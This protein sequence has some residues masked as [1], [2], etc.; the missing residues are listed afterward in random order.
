[1]TVDKQLYTP[2]AW[3]TIFHSLEHDEV[4]GAGAAGPGKS[5]V[6]LMDPFHWQI[7]TEHER[8]KNP[9]HPHRLPWGGSS[10]WA[11]HLRRT[12]PMLELSI[13]R[14]HRI[15]PLIDAGAKWNENK[16]T[17]VFRSGYRFQ[18]G[19]CHDSEDWQNYLSFEFTHIGYDELIQFEEEQYD[20][21]N[22]R[23]RSSDPVLRTMLKIRATTNPLMSKQK[24]DNFSIKDP[25]WVRRRFVDDAPEGKVT[26][27][28]K[29]KMQDGRVVEHKR[30]YL[31]ATLFD[32][33]DKQFVQDYEAKL[34]NAK[35]HIRQ[36]LLYGN[37]YVT[38]GS[39]YGDVWNT[40]L[41]TCKPFK[42][43]KEWPKFRSM[44]WGFKMPGVVHWYAMDPDG[45]L[46]CFRE[47]VFQGMQAKAV[48]EAILQI[49]KGYG[50]L[51]RGKS[52]LT[53]P[54][55]TQLWEDRGDGTKGKAMEM[56]EA[57]VMW[58]PAKKG[59]G[60]RLR[61]AELLYDRLADHDSGT[62]TPGIVF[63][64][65]CAEVIKLIPSVGTSDKNS[66]EPADGNDDHALDTCFYA[67]GYASHGKAG[68]GWRSSDADDRDEDDEKPKPK[69]G[70]WGYG[71]N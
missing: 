18:F 53:G 10:G 61:N 63:F 46:F 27:V 5:M 15:F 69:K 4:L 26:F 32:N 21:I 45:N 60:S 28:K 6:L 30:I 55:D 12:R 2:S 40:R 20:Q 38:A 33:P 70:R 1:M 50:L 42:I 17:W 64:E 56:A 9:D 57:G 3:G 11:L 29:L 67:C 58:V 36:A 62:T 52:I 71:V 49:E 43:P 14:S 23:L 16:A 31:P 34:Q 41:H 22:T 54:A 39:F 65:G 19:H 35:P 59:P 51:K 8:C 44:D 25:N 37:W 47:L 48:A 66:E 24:G 7:T 68:L 13:Q